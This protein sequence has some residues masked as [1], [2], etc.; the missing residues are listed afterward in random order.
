M[1]SCLKI[2]LAI[3]ISGFT[4]FHPVHVSVINIDYFSA[5]KEMDVSFKVFT[6]DFQLLFIHLYET[7]IGFNTKE[8]YWH[9]KER[10]D[11]Y[12][13]S[14]FQLSDN[15]KKYSLKFMGL[16]KN[17]DSVWFNY[18]IENLESNKEL[19][20]VNT[21]LLDLYMDQKN[22]VFF[23][24]GKTEKGYQYDFKNREYYINLK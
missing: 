17:D 4:F 5:K 20:L 19:K 21:V 14:H 9:A 7:K 18:K 1:I 3:L 6:D 8:E 13:N 12:F 24:S 10:I 23:K 2:Y 22:L 16:K 11:Q 15:E